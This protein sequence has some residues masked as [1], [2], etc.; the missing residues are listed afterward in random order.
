MEETQEGIEYQRV[1]GI[2]EFSSKM[3]HR[4]FQETALLS[5][6]NDTG[7]VQ[8]RKKWSLRTLQGLES[9]E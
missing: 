3:F 9:T 7:L 8:S 5:T 1:S 4:N 2:H 6:L